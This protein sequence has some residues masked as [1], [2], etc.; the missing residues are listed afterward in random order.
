MHQLFGDQVDSVIEELN[1][2]AGGVTD[3][4]FPSGWALVP[5]EEGLAARDEKSR[6]FLVH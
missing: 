3:E 5:I 4:S 6:P 2:G 1:G